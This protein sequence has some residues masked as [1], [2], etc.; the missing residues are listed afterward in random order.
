RRRLTSSRQVSNALFERNAPPT[1]TAAQRQSGGLQERNATRTSPAAWM[2]TA[3]CGTVARRLQFA[4][5]E[6]QH[7]PHPW[8][9]AAIRSRRIA[10]LPRDVR[11]RAYREA[12]A[13][14]PQRAVCSRAARA[15]RR[16]S[17][18]REARA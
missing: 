18:V 13:A 16:E 11:D 7:F 1:S 12:L 3:R 2:H 10:A 17:S 15:D 4:P 5:G 8:G 14:V 9:S 6:L